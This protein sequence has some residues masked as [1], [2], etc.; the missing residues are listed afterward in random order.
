MITAL[1]YSLIQISP[2]ILGHGTSPVT[3][4]FLWNQEFRR[5]SDELL[6]KGTK[7]QPDM[8]QGECLG[9]NQEFAA[10]WLAEPNSRAGHLS[11]WSKI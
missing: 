10:G 7:Q 8:Y 4:L 6:P 3:L 1:C 5:V 9:E 11:T 2:N